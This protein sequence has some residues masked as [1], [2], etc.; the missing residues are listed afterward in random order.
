MHRKLTMLKSL[1]AKGSNMQKV[2]QI[3]AE[4]LLLSLNYYLKVIRKKRRP[5]NFPLIIFV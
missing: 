5:G 1:V 4:F 2:Q 3:S